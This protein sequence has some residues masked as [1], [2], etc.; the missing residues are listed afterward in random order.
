MGRTERHTHQAAE[1]V[2]ANSV[3][4]ASLEELLQ[5][6]LDNLG[7]GGGGVFVNALSSATPY[8]LT[9]SSVKCPLTSGSLDAGTYSSSFDLYDSGSG[10]ADSLRYQDNDGLGDIRVDVTVSFNVKHNA[11]DGRELQFRALCYLNDSAQGGGHTYA[12]TSP[13]NASI[14]TVERT[15]PMTLTD[16]D[17]INYRV[18][19]IN[20]E[21]GSGGLLLVAGAYSDSG[22]VDI[23]TTTATVPF[24]TE[25]VASDDMTLNVDGSISLPIGGYYDMDWTVPVNDDGSLGTTRG[26]IFGWVEYDAN[27]DGAGYVAIPNS[28]G[29]DYARETSGGEGVNGGGGFVAASG[30]RIRLR[31]QSS[32]TVDVSAETGQASLSIHRVPSP[33]SGS[34]DGRVEPF[35]YQITLRQAE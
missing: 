33:D 9:G 21:S 3:A 20:S 30:S 23:T 16:G 17:Y 22:S 10:N 8:S 34:E 32:S 29:Q 6:I 18:A 13:S 19:Y 35:G 24:D 31:I 4:G 7:G 14:V 26:R 25:D 28:Y 12:I 27:D 5:Y 1:V 11:D 15:T 2:M